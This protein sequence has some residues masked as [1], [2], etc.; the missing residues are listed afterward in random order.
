MSDLYKLSALDAAA[1]LLRHELT[2]EHYLRGL[3]ERIDAREPTVQAFVIVAREQALA[4]ARALDAGPIRGPL[5][6]LAVGIKDIFDTYDMPTQGGSDAYAGHQPTIDAA[7]VALTRRA[8][9]IIIGKTVTTELATFPAN[10]T[11]NPH[12]PEHTPGGSS[13]GSAAAV[14]DGMIPLATG[15]QTLGS[16]IR[17]ASY[18]GAVAFK[19][20]YNLIPRKGVW[21]SSDSNDTVGVFGRSVA[22]VAFYVSAMLHFDKLRVPANVAAPKIGLC[23]TYQWDMATP[24]MKAALEQAGRTLAAAGAKVVDLTLPSRFAGLLEAQSICSRRETGHSYA[25]ETSRAGDKLNPALYERCLEGYAVPGEDYQRAQT[26]VRECRYHLAGAMGDCDVLL[27]PAATGEA[28]KGL[29]S[30][31]DPVFNQVWTYLHVPLVAVPAGRGPAGLPLG[32]Q[33]AGRLDDD[34]RTLAAAHWIHQRLNS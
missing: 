30:T 1:R 22:D 29:G 18:C 17:P 33:V 7:A 14:A 25:D 20:T 3:L 19:P 31:G 5:H 34:A 8:G 13:S 24:A 10:K 16:V 28:P 21:N 2:A 4:A 23:R 9:G 26:L 12:N 27:A 32:L 11:R 15:T 6:G